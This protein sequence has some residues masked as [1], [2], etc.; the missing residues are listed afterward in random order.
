MKK[1]NDGYQIWP[2]YYGH[3]VKYRVVKFIS[4]EVVYER[5]FRS[6][7]EANGYV[8]KQEE[9]VSKQMQMDLE[10]IE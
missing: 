10:P 3:E 4:G 9:S 5:Q 2:V 1:A 8:I 6:R 7:D